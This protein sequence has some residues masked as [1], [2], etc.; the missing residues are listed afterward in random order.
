MDEVTCLLPPIK[1][2]GKAILETFCKEVCSVDVDEDG[3]DNAVAIREENMLSIIEVFCLLQSS[4][5]P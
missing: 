4:S 3:V 2:A 5:T 1:R